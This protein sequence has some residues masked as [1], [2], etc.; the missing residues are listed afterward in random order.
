MRTVQDIARD[1]RAGSLAAGTM[2]VSVKSSDII[3]VAS[4]LLGVPEYDE[5]IRAKPATVGDSDGQPGA[6][7]ADADHTGASDPVADSP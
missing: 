3:A 2:Y 6:S 7:V 5:P 4:A 1:V